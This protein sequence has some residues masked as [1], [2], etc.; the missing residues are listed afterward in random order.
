MRIPT[1]A[2]HPALTVRS[3]TPTHRAAARRTLLAKARLPI[4][5]LAAPPP[6]R[7]D[8]VKPTQPARVAG[9]RLTTKV[10]ARRGGGPLA[11]RP[12]IPRG[13]PPPTPPPGAG[14][15]TTPPTTARRIPR[16]LPPLR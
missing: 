5:L 13:L 7:K 1:A 6:T 12:T 3:I 14:R 8:P 4:A 9:R 10:T 11:R 2:A 16:T 15:H